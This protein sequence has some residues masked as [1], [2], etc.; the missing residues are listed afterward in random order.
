MRPYGSLAV[1]TLMVVASAA[2][3]ILFRLWLRQSHRP[4]SSRG[5]LPWHHHD[6]MS[7][8]A[9]NTVNPSETIHIDDLISLGPSCLAAYHFRRGGWRKASLPFDWTLFDDR[10]QHIPQVARLVAAKFAPL[11]SLQNNTSPLHYEP[12]RALHDTDKANRSVVHAGIPTMRW[13]H[14]D[15]LKNASKVVRRTQRLIS[16]LA[17]PSTRRRVF[18]LAYGSVN[19]L[20]SPIEAFAAQ[21]KD[22]TLALESSFTSLIG[23][24]RIL[25]IVHARSSDPAYRALVSELEEKLPRRLM[26]SAVTPLPESAKLSLTPEEMLWGNTGAW[27]SLMRNKFRR[28]TPNDESLTT[29]LE[30]FSVTPYHYPRGIDGPFTRYGYFVCS[31]SGSQRDFESLDTNSDGMLSRL[32]LAAGDGERQG[33]STGL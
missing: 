8:L 1:A 2:G 23:H 7:M 25:I 29:C 27:A 17:S 30:R 13:I 32:E 14:D 11:L 22:L 12:Y 24:Y 18:T 21:L 9:P 20:P 31:K 33:G 4:L 10:Q 6:S 3:W 15:P 19:E 26:I 28:Y 16:I 5:A